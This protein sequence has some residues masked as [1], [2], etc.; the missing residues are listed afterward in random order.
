MSSK[1]I[2][3]YKWKALINFLGEKERNITS[4]GKEKEKEKICAFARPSPEV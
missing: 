4:E 3:Y 2:N 1:I